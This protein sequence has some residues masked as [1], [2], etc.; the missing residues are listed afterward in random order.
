[1]SDPSVQLTAGTAI[2]GNIFFPRPT[3]LRASKA[4][5]GI[6]LTLPTS[7][8]ISEHERFA[9][10]PMVS[11]VSAE[12][13]LHG[14]EVGL[15]R[16]ENHYYGYG[17]PTDGE[18]LLRLSAKAVQHIE[19]E[20]AGGA[21]EFDLLVRFEIYSLMPTNGESRM[22]SEPRPQ[23]KD[24]RV[25]YD[26]DSWVRMLTSTGMGDNIVVEVPLPASPPAGWEDVWTALRNARRAYEQGG[27]TGW[28]STVVECRKALSA[29]QGI[30]NEKEDMGAGWKK[31]S[32]QE[33]EG[34]TT[35]Q[36]LD[37]VRWHLLQCAH[38][39]AHTPAE[40]WTRNEAALVMATLAGLLAI[41][42]P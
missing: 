3:A 1:M 7:I 23:K 28:N 41:R 9:G 15:A 20:R 11:N 19:R 40:K 26:R 42:Q 39:A 6:V 36:R 10:L 32:Q 16:D 14:V 22:R 33:L 18:L 30:P 12:V 24:V 5:D 27:S 37:N 2:L 21:V 13:R 8:Q 29:W 17:S 25:P 35:G 4:S 31:P 38:E 34:R